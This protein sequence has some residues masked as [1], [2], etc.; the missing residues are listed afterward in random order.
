[1]RRTFDEYPPGAQ[2]VLLVAE[3]LFGE[4]GLAGASLRQITAAAGQANNSIVHHYFGSRSGLIQA[5]Y[6][7]RVPVLERGRQQLL[8]AAGET[9]SL[10]DLLGALLFPILTIGDP[11]ARERYARFSERV[12]NLPPESDPY[13]PAVEIMPAAHEIN[14]QLVLRGNMP[15]EMVNVRLRHASR[16]FVTGVAD[17]GRVSAVP[18]ADPAWEQAYWAHIFALACAIMTAPHPARPIPAAISAQLA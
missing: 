13:Y 3:R 5:V 17:F 1:M 12:T 15:E 11:V 4:H 7:M 6:E 18:H 8:D 9:P 10:E 16:M 14:R 2:K